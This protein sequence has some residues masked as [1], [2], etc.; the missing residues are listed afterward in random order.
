MR[1][2]LK[3]HRFLLRTFLILVLVFLIGFL[4]AGFIISYTTAGDYVDAQRSYEYEKMRGDADKL[5][6]KLINISTAIMQTYQMD[7][8]RESLSTLLAKPGIKGSEVSVRE[9]MV[10][11]IQS[12]P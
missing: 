10:K 5:N 8:D 12:S 1:L 6:E 11:T 3:K 7:D 4:T 2:W 9:F